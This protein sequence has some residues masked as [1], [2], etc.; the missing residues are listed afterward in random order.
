MV[1]ALLM[2]GTFMASCARTKSSARLL[3]PREEG[4]RP[5]AAPNP[6]YQ[7]A[8]NAERECESEALRVCPRGY[9]RSAPAA[10]AA[11]PNATQANNAAAQGSTGAPK[12]SGWLFRG[13]SGHVFEIECS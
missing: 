5:G 11:A 1:F 9:V 6:R 13:G 10:G 2:M 4:R 3:P 12:G 8:C 7:I